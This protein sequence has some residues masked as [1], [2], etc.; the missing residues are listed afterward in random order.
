MTRDNS[1]KSKLIKALNELVSEGKKVS[2]F[3][4]EKRAG[5]SNGLVRHHEDV[6]EMINQAKLEAAKQ[7]VKG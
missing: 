1:K 7:P 5:V 6:M 4:V 2:P 3:S